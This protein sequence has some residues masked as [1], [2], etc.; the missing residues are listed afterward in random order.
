MD[1]IFCSQKK[2]AVKRGGELE[3]I[4]FLQK[5]ILFS[6]FFDDISHCF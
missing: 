6:S 1:K 4:K 5:V 3:K 2:I